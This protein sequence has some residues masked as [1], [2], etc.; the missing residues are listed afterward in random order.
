MTIS[1]RYF[2]FVLVV[3]ARKW[4]FT[5]ISDSYV[6]PLNGDCHSLF[7]RKLNASNCRTNQWHLAGSFANDQFGLLR[8][9]LL[10]FL[11][12]KMD[13]FGFRG[14][15]HNFN[16]AT[17]SIA[18]KT[19]APCATRVEC[20]IV[21]SWPRSMFCF[22]TH[23]FT[24]MPYRGWTAKRCESFTWQ[25]PMNSFFTSIDMDLLEL[26]PT[27]SIH[28]SLVGR[29]YWKNETISNPESEGGQGWWL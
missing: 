29:K 9:L 17:E 22:L 2:W 13:K 26:E 11:F 21:S 20:V 28:E 18:Q 23:N 4:R 6:W 12:L 24:S 3:S 5:S 19:H 7:A 25:N 1:I 10:S 16:R 8:L 27:H 15:G 14:E